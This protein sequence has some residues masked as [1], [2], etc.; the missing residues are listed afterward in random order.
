MIKA[1]FMDFYG[2][3]AMEIGPIAVSVIK[4]VYKNSK[5]QSP[6]DILGY[7]WKT[8][9]EKQN[10]ANGENFKTQ[11]EVALENF[12]ELARHFQCTMEPEK[13]LERMEEHWCSSPLYDD[14]K[15]FLQS[16]PLPVYFVTNS[17]NRYIMEEIKRYSLHPA[18]IVTSEEAKYSKPR[19]E[20]FLYV[21][22]K[23]GVSPEE[24]IHVGDS[25]EGDVKCPSSVGIRSIWLNRERKPVP[26]GVESID[27][28]RSL[29]KNNYLVMETE[30]QGY[31]GWT[32][33]KGQL[34]LQ[35]YSHLAS[36][37]NS[38]M[39]WHWHSIHNSFETYWKGL[40]SHDFQENAAYREACV[41]GREFSEMGSHLINLKKKNDAAILVSNEALTALKWFGIQ[42]AAAGN[43]GIGYNDV[44]R[45][46]Y[47]ALYQMNIECDFVW[48][49]L[50]DFSQYKAI[51]VPALYAAPDTLLEKLNRYVAEGG[52]LVATF[53]TAFANENV[54][55]SHE[56][57]PHI[58][59][60][61][62]GVKYHQFTFP[63]NVGLSGRIIGENTDA[64]A[65]I[66]MEL[67]IPQ[68]AEVL[69]SYEHYNWKEY[70]AVTKNHYGKGTAVYMGCMTDENTLKA[71]ITDVL[72]C[73]QVEIPA[74]DYPVIVRKGI[75]DFGKNVRYFLN[76]SAE[77]Q[78]VPYRYGN[79]VDLLSGKTVDHGEIIAIPAWDLKIVEE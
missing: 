8:F 39:Y 13:L 12:R 46:I 73:A 35:A 55:V 53:K 6:E 19:K 2:T 41:I 56:V 42:A 5:A 30:A 10:L 18:G 31:P 59:N 58:L 63:K 75:N 29:K 33:Y 74:Y 72:Q 44:V 48:P 45:W 76:Y 15:E 67:L 43:N 3:A 24:V 77:E 9:R 62:F 34:R 52:T 71:V 7:W 25:L 37:S 65:R 64:E 11:H 36:G 49:E 68:G 69:A 4:D 60:D 26:A 16:C 47:N 17:D 51:F 14:V 32:P 61:C 40:L 79:G 21:F 27:M 23:A 38:V 20:I 28:T 22:K 66:F 70:A 50:E 1:I 78:K 54:K 57:Q